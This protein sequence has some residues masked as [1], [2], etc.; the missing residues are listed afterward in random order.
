MGIGSCDRRFRL[1]G[2]NACRHWDDQIR[3]Q[4]LSSLGALLC[5]GGEVQWGGRQLAQVVVGSPLHDVEWLP[6]YVP[7]LHPAQY[8]H[9]AAMELLT[10]EG[11][12]ALMGSRLCFL[13]VITPCGCAKHAPQNAAN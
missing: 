6:R 11:F 13:R 1:R 8:L 2:I 10:S 3:S 7:A 9:R 12:A 4:T 5:P